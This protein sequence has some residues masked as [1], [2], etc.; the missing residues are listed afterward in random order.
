MPMTEARVGDQAVRYDREATAA[1]Y[2]GLK[3]GY[4]EECGCVFCRNF[5]ARR[6]LI[7]PASFRGLLAE[8][9]IDPDK[10][11][12]AFEYGPVGEGMHLNWVLPEPPEYRTA[13]KDTR[14]R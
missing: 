11:V 6:H 8:I 9:G 3:H 13:S 1:I 14:P 2:G 5:A 7:Y 4:A 12:E 10:E